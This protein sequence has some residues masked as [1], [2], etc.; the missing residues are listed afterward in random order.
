MEQLLLLERD[1]GR[2][3][4]S[5]DAGLGRCGELLILAPTSAI[6]KKRVADVAF[7]T[8]HTEPLDGTRLHWS[9]L[10]LQQIIGVSLARK[11]KGVREAKLPPS[12]M[13]R[14][15]TWWLLSAAV[16]YP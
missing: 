2:G 10:C 15:R 4:E 5:A 11:E 1:R 6:K 16:K 12:L 3:I 14:A 9:V 8:H 13:L 7:T